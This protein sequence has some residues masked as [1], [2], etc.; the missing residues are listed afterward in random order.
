MEGLDGVAACFDCFGLIGDCCEKA[1]GG[2][3]GC[4]VRRIGLGRGG[5]WLLAERAERCGTDEPEGEGAPG[6]ARSQVAVSHAGRGVPERAEGEN[7]EVRRERCWA[8][9]ESLGVRLRTGRRSSRDA[10]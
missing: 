2:C 10:R 6:K 7:G 5:L 1:G 3:F 4:L 9:A 8:M